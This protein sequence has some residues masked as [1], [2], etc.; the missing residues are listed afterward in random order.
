MIQF[1]VPIPT[2]GALH[3]GHLNLVQKAKEENDIVVVSIYINPT[4]FAEHEDLDVY[5][6]DLQSD[7][8]LLEALGVDVV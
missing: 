6:R 4:Q 7:V 2:M 8:K 5:P 3:A 1:G